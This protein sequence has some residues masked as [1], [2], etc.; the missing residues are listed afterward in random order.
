MQTFN[1]IASWAAIWDAVLRNSRSKCVWREQEV[2]DQINRHAQRTSQIGEDS[3]VKCKDRAA[4]IVENAAR[5][6]VVRANRDRCLGAV[7]GL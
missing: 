2:V 1:F 5:K 3:L 6:G 7:H 4:L